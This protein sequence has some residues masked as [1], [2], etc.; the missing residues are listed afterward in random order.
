MCG[1]QQRQTKGWVRAGVVAVQ[2]QPQCSSQIRHCTCLVAE[3]KQGKLC[4]QGVHVVWGLATGGCPG[5]GLPH[6]ERPLCRVRRRPSVPWCLRACHWRLHR[7]PRRRTGPPARCDAAA[8]QSLGCPPLAPRY[9]CPTGKKRGT[10][11]PQSGSRSMEVGRGE[12]DKGG[13]K[14]RHVSTG[15]Q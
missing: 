14:L 1:A 8:P 13:R 7:P 2:G 4:M 11:R 15:V 3:N 6:V 9:A 10:Q 12:E 5:W